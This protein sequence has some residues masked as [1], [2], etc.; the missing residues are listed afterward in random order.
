MSI[1]GQETT[2]PATLPP[3]QSPPTAPVELLPPQPVHAIPTRSIRANSL[4]SIS[5]RTSHS[6][7]PAPVRDNEA[8]RSTRQL[9][10][11]L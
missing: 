9:R 3:H 7:S 10:D 5:H 8:E 11:K 4:S 6:A 2:E 1:T